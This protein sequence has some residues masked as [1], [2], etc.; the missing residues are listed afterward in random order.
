MNT[1][2]NRANMPTTLSSPSP[3]LGTQESK[4]TWA[5]EGHRGREA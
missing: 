2:E 3:L 4:E 5:S 1:N